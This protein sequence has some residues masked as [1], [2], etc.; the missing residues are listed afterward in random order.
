MEASKPSGSAEIEPDSTR[1]KKHLDQSRPKTRGHLGTAL[2]KRKMGKALEPRRISWRMPHELVYKSIIEIINE[3]QNWTLADQP[4][5]LHSSHHTMLPSARLLFVRYLQPGNPV[6]YYK[7]QC[8]LV[9]IC[10]LFIQ[11]QV[12]QLLSTV[13]LQGTLYINKKHIGG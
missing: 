3:L 13:S 4:K 6:S 12:C 7:V 5:E 11:S 9:V 2:D 1:P 8:W 10:R